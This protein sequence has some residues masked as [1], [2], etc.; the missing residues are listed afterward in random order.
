MRKKKLETVTLLGVDCLDIDRLGYVAEICKENFEFADVKLLSSKKS[1]KY[2]GIIPIKH[3]GS[4]AEYSKFIIEELDQYVDTP[5]VLIIQ[6]DGFILNKDA[7]MD[8]FLEYDYVGAPWLINKW[9]VETFKIPKDLVGKEVVGNGGFCMRSKKLLSLSAKLSKDKF[10]KEC[11]PEDVVL[12]IFYRKL[13][14]EN[15]IKFAPVKIAKRF[16]FE[17]EDKENDKWTDQFG[18]HGLRWTDISSWLERNKQHKIV[19]KSST[20]LSGY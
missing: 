13:L 14:E 19:N 3:L 11:H 15:G 17:A 1:K 18:F 10:F 5:N 2:E 7:W 6:Y 20:F 12:C 4:T 16:S 8:E 9:S